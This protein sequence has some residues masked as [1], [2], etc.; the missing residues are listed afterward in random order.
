MNY[1]ISVVITT[2]NRIKKIERAIKSVLNQTHKN[3]ELIVVDDGSN[4]GTHNLIKSKYPNIIL[5]RNDISL[6]GSVARNI[7]WQIC[8]GKFISFLDDDDY[9]RKDKLEIQLK[10]FL[11]DS[12]SSLVVC[13]YFSIKN[14]KTIISKV[15]KKN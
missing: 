10:I 7:G 6:G 4:D 5:Q 14:N 8:K 9:F 1:L 11:S 13:N 12:Q 15:K 2:K 3:I